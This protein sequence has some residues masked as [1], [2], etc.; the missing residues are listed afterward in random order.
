M[1]LTVVKPNI[2][3]GRLDKL[4]IAEITLFKR[5]FYKTKVGKI[6]S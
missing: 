1:Q 3:Q 5:A 2:V 6:G 4:C